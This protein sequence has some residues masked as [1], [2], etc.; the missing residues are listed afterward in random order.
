M[1]EESATFETELYLSPRAVLAALPL[2]GVV[3]H[4]M[5][6]LWLESRSVQA[7]SLF[8]LL[9]L[10]LACIGWL[11]AY[12]KAQAGRWFALLA[13]LLA[14]HLADFWLEMP[15]AQVLVTIP[16]ALATALLGPMPGLYVAVGEI[17][18][19][20]VRLLQA[21]SEVARSQAGFMLLAVCLVVALLQA[22]SGSARHVAQWAWRYYKDAQASLVEAR[23]RKVELEQALDDL[24]HAN[25]QIALSNERIAALRQIAEEARRSKETFVARVSHE[26]R[27]PLN[28]IIG[29]INL[30]V[31]TPEIYEGEFPPR[32]LEHLRIVYR[33]CQHLASMINDV[34]DL[35]RADA[36]R[37]TLHRE[38]VDLAEVIDTS[39]NVVRPLI[40]DKGLSWKVELPA[41]L[42]RVYCDRVRIRQV[43][44]NLLSNAARFT[45]R[46]GIAVHVTHND[47]YITIRVSDTGPGI[48]PED[49]GR[50]FEPFYQASDIWLTREGSGLGLSISKKFVELHGGRMW[51]ESAL[52][53]GTT[54]FVELPVAEPPP[55]IVRPAGWIKEE[56]PWIERRSRPDLPASLFKP[57]VLICDETGDLCPA[58]RR[59]S[60]EVEFVE[61]TDL[62]A[63]SGALEDGTISAVIINAV[64]PE[65]VWPAL[66]EVRKTVADIPIIGCAYLPRRERALAAGAV[67]YLIKPLTGSD[68]GEV[69][70]RLDRPIRRVLIVDDDHDTCELLAFFV[71]TYDAT[72]EI[73]VVENGAQAL[74]A[75]RARPPDVVLLDVVMPELDGWHVLEMRNRDAALQ[76]IPV[77]II[78]AQDPRA[79]PWVSP[80]VVATLREGLPAGKMW[81]CSA[82]L[83]SILM[84]PT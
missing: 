27:T 34:L 77:I 36:G 51:V 23:N 17:A 13:A 6:S 37:I 52:G 72:I 68:L 26:F 71:H 32:A 66:E 28:I 74:A 70:A 65:R 3:L 14:V 54:F 82:A 15:G 56:W 69:L 57:R 43:I 79:Q 60:D 19:A 2:F 9:M 30:M 35:S 21:G 49:V 67:D 42:P 59:C 5:N 12:W 24:Q 38:Q 80:V 20:S 40:E 47:G 75:M 83:C 11:L 18:L 45:E 7:C 22:V 61:M 44:L 58:L 55:H 48:S 39:L 46:G 8:A 25:R 29:M 78:S 62:R 50:I 64:T 53:S 4:L 81:D 76:D 84:R 41:D 63:V 33:N 1:Y 31:E 10:V 73:T 16:V